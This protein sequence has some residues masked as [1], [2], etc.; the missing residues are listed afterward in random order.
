MQSVARQGS[1][2]AWL[3]LPRAVYDRFATFIHELGKFGV[4][5]TVCYF[6]DVGIFRLC[7]N[8]TGW[9]WALVISTVIAT[10]IA[11]TGNRF[12][13]WRRRERTGLRREYGLYFSF[14]LVGLVIGV[15][16]LFIS[17]ELLGSL[18]AAFQTKTADTISGKVIG[19]G[20]ASVFR[21][22]AYRRF[23]FP[24]TRASLAPSDPAG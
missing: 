6:I 9:F 14:N 23:V 22:W 17:H 16:V 20:L 7:L 8:F 2:P 10:T 4:V 15:V 18:W 24:V 21:F 19:V 13:T 11:F 3:A 1:R 12:W 5:G